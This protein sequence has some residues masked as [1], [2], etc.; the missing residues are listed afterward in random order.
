M[1][2]GGAEERDDLFTTNWLQR[3]KK[4]FQNG[5]HSHGKDAHFGQTKGVTRQGIYLIVARTEQTL[6]QVEKQR[7]S[8]W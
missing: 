3:E 8:V 6:H 7:K 5:C 4:T 1:R 2:A